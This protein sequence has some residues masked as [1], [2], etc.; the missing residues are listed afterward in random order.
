MDSTRRAKTVR[1]ASI[2]IGTNTLL[3]LIAD[4][5]E[6]G[7]LVLVHHE[8]RFP[9]IGRSVDAEGRISVAS[10]DR[11]AWILN[12]YKNLSQ[13][14]GAEQ[15]VACATSAVR[16]AVNKDEF[17]AY[18]YQTTGLKIRVLSGEE[19]AILTYRG[20]A[21][22]LTTENKPAVVIDIGGGSTEI[23][24]P[25]ASGDIA[26]IQKMSLQL[27]AVRITERFFKHD[28]P[29]L[30]EEGS[31]RKYIREILSASRFLLYEQVNLIGVAG[32][33]TSLACLDQQLKEFIPNK[34]EGYRL[35]VEKING[36]SKTLAGLSSGEIL[37]LSNVTEGRADILT[38]GCLILDEIMAHFRFPWILASI[39]GL[40]YGL[41][42]V[43][44][45]KL[46]ERPRF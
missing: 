30:G 40:R 5:D 21:S 10:F 4:I 14:F 46:N 6:S 20:A 29:T 45:E 18:L 28:P 35:S 2:D 23:I 36:W 24:G 13:Q 7:R 17:I 31:A 43:T 15:I 44:S 32:T 12:E 33:V 1:I 16:D 39:R 25:T 19:E 37:S 22:G 8:Q 38:A 42:F 9:R 26:R 11:T 27:G 3:L 41:A 34:V